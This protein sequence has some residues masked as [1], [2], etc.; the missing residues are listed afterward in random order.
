[1][2]QANVHLGIR[3]R[4]VMEKEAEIPVLTAGCSQQDFGFFK[5]EWRLYEESSRT[6][7]N[8]LLCDQLLQCAE[9][10]LRKKLQNTIGADRMISISV[11]DLMVEI[12]KATMEKQSDLL[13]MAKQ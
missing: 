1:M 3:P 12:E 11:A 4:G 10:I 8:T 6:L 7:D 9:T 13:N 5:D 2:E